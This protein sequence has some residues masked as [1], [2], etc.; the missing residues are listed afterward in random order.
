MPEA[1]FF[2]NEWSPGKKQ[3]FRF[4]FIFLLLFILINPNNVIP[5]FSF[6]QKF[7]RWP[8]YHLVNWFGST[9]FNI[10]GTLSNTS[11]PAT[12]T[13]S[14]YLIVLFTICTAVIGSVFWGLVDRKS[15]NYSKINEALI[16][17]LR[18]YLGLTWI[19]YATLKIV[20]L[21]FPENLILV[22]SC[23]KTGVS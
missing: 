15:P 23:E 18:Y 21:Q 13:V 19:T 7:T 12:D 3:I 1:N 16:I 2:I 4:S 14:N 22:L 10:P 17:T 6:V 11:H 8:Y 20:H 9:F 5:Y